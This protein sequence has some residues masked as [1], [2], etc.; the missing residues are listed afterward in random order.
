MTPTGTPT[1]GVF[2]FNVSP[3]PETDGK[4]KFQWG[5]TIK[6]RE[7][8]IKI[9]TSGFRL[10]EQFSFDKQAHSENLSAGEHEMSWDGKDEQGR[11]MPSGNYLCFVV[12]ETEKKDYE[13][14]A[15]TN[16]P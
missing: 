16:I 4:I 8:N 11:A 10:V 1:P 9:F 3:K 13:A 2:K 6:A 7:I 5:T 15:K 14:S 12:I